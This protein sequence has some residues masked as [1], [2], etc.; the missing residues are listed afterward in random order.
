MKKALLPVTHYEKY[1]SHL[2]EVTRDDIIEKLSAAEIR[3][4]ILNDYELYRIYVENIKFP[5]IGIN[6][7]LTSN[8]L[9]Q[10]YLTHRY[11]KFYHF[12]KDITDLLTR[13]SLKKMDVDLI[14]SPYPCIYLS[15][16]HNETLTN[17][18]QYTGTHIVEGIYVY[19]KEIDQDFLKQYPNMVQDTKVI[20]RCLMVGKGKK[21]SILGEYDDNLNFT[22]IF[23][24]EGDIFEQLDID[25]KR[26][27]ENGHMA[28]CLDIDGLKRIHSFVI[29]ALL[30]ITSAQ[31]RLDFC[32]TR[33]PNEYSGRKPKKVRQ[34]EKQNKKYST[35]N[36][37][38]NVGK[39]IVIRANIP[40]GDS[41]STGATI[42]LSAQI[43]VH[44]HWQWYWIGKGR[45]QRKHVFKVEYVKGKEFA[46]SLEKSRIVK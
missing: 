34:A 30:Y 36:Q 7:S 1:V 6:Q 41:R 14:K 23:L 15:I 28:E 18:D 9:S 39:D 10:V 21:E 8:V 35:M 11:Q 2:K 43:K 33:L 13:T 31:A 12:E 4:D 24:G 38:C 5:P 17:Q 44:P 19:Y 46:E 42:T 40:S 37:F 3:D 16:P 32:G 25:I 20:L 22:T 27:Q 29:N 45:T 26:K